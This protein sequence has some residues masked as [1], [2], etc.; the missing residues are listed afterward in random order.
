MQRFLYRHQPSPSM[1]TAVLAGLGAAIAVALLAFANDKVGLAMLM[2]PLGASCVLLFGAPAAPFS[3]PINIVVGH[4]MSAAIGLVLH[5]IM[6]GQFFVAGIAAGIAVTAMMA[7]RVVHPPS[8]ATALVAYLTATSWSF[9]VFPVAVGSLV[10]VA[11]ATIYHRVVG[12][13]YP[14]HLPVEKTEG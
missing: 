3:Q 14:A 7:F 4:M 10:L 12:T 1:R 2:A 8:G 13:A 6:P 9:L 5:S 11:I